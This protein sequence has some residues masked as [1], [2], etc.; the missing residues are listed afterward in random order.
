MKVSWPHVKVQCNTG[1]APALCLT[2]V[3][4]DYHT[5]RSEASLVL[6]LSSDVLVKSSVP[7][8]YEQ[9]SVCCAYF[10]GTLKECFVSRSPP[11][12]AGDST[13]PVQEQCA[14][15]PK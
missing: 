12:K 7:A 9:A 14:F 3:G 15:I 6:V 4:K 11:F 1:N 5:I 2:R 8:L 10:N 13:F